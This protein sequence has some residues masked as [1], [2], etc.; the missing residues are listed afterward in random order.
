MAARIVTRSFMK[1]V[2]RGKAKVVSWGW[3]VVG[4][5]K[6]EKKTQGKQVTVYAKDIVV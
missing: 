5:L 1:K 6:E 2:V 3:L 4:E